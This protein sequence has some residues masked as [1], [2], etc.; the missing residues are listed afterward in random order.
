MKYAFIEKLAEE[1]HLSSNDKTN[2]YHDCS[3]ILTKA[4]GVVT[5]KAVAEG[6]KE[7][8]Q[9]LGSRFMAHVVRNGMYMAYL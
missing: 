3:L 4:A 9:Q 2:I 5:P 8:A 7:L 1:G 6:F